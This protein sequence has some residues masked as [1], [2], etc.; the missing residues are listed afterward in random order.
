VVVSRDIQVAEHL[1]IAPFV[2]SRVQKKKDG[3]YFIENFFSCAFSALV[4]FG[5]E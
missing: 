3:I 4:I 2:M 1:K 5:G